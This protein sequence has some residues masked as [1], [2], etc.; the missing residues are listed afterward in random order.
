LQTP[1]NR[2][3]LL[4]KTN[5][6]LAQTGIWTFTL[7][8]ASFFLFEGIFYVVAFLSGKSHTLN[9]Q[10]IP[11][12]LIIYTIFVAMLSKYLSIILLKPINH[13]RQVIEGFDQK[14]IPRAEKVFFNIKELMELKKFLTR[15][16]SMQKE[17]LDKE[18]EFSK[19]SRQ[20]AHDIRTPLLA[21]ESMADEFEMEN[22]EQARLMRKVAT[23]VN[24]IA[25]SFL[26]E[27]RQIR[28][29][30]KKELIFPLVEAVVLEKIAQQKN[31]D[32]EIKLKIDDNVRFSCAELNASEF[33]RV[34][35]N[36]LD[37]A[38]QAV[39]LS[40]GRISVLVI[41]KG[42]FIRIDIE[43]NGCG[44][45]QGNLGFIFKEGVSIGKRKGH[46]YGLSYVKKTVNSMRGKLEI[47]STIGKGTMVLID[48][49]ISSVANWLTH[50]S[51]LNDII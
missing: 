51:L 9:F 38:V 50:R 41:K 13:F 2:K 49:P 1:N 37:N 7:C 4:E 8:V 23:R 12:A 36:L 40:K 6:L 19:I 27:T 3:N 39:D 26:N 42:D 30:N 18:A 11:V 24:S 20:I 14:Q 25:N 47:K 45:S 44:I 31:G 15:V 22:L 29:I 46:G 33:M 34:I 28:G 35:S 5:T 21:L 32:Y 43:D 17:K 48:L 16:F 10:L